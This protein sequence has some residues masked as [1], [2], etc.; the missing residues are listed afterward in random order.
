[1]AS[2][3]SRQRHRD[4]GRRAAGAEDDRLLTQRVKMGVLLQREKKTRAVGVVSVKLSIAQHDRIH[5]P[6][7]FRHRVQLVPK[8]DHRT[9]VRQ[10]DVDA[11]DIQR[12]Q[13]ERRLA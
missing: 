2:T 1:M 13:R 12:A 4:R 6:D 3:G 5:R 7:L 9:F 11:G 8:L 10:G